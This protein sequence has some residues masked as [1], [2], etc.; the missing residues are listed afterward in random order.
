M[1]LIN[2]K[3]VVTRAV[4]LEPKQVWMA[5]IGAKSFEMVEPEPEIWLPFSEMVCGASELYK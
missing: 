1:C 4:D 2:S 3:A 5:G